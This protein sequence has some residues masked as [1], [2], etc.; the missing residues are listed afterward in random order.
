MNIKMFEGGEVNYYDNPK[1]Y[2][3]LLITYLFF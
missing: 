2:K 3:Q 1:G